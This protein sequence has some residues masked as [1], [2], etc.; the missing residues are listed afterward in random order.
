MGWH[1]KKDA[2]ME[3]GR[4]DGRQEGRLENTLT[5]FGELNVRAENFLRCRIPF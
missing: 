5:G 3:M 1:P 2:E 4:D